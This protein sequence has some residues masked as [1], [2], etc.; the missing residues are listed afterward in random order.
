MG[1]GGTVPHMIQ[2]RYR[3]GLENAAR[4]YPD[5]VDLVQKAAV[6]RMIEDAFLP[7]SGSISA[8]GLSRSTSIDAAKYHEQVDARL[9]R[10]RDALSG[11]RC[12]VL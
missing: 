5:L 8:D 9:D 12:L 10:L 2:V 4:D 6:L 11:V 1:G 7:Q 3:A